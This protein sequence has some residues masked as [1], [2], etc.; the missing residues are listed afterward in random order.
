VTVATERVL[1]CD[2]ARPGCV[3]SLRVEVATVPA[4]RAAARGRG[5]T[6]TSA[7]VYDVCPRC[8]DT[9]EFTARDPLFIAAATLPAARQVASERGLPPSLWIYLHDPWV[10]LRGRR[11]V[12]V[13]RGFG[14]DD[15]RSPARRRFALDLA[16]VAH[17]LGPDGIRW[18]D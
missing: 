6:R 2:V 17:L 4:A 15:T 1:R 9:G 14:W 12:A 7:P 10:Q 18:V 16:D 11:R 13:H 5:W 8:G 3:G